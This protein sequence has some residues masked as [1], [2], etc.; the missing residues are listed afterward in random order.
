MRLCDIMSWH[1]ITHPRPV[2]DVNTTPFL[3]IQSMAIVT[4]I[5]PGKTCSK[6]MN[7]W[8]LFF[9]GSLWINHLITGHCCKESMRELI[10][11][12]KEYMSKFPTGNILFTWSD[13][14]RRLWWRPWCSRR[15]IRVHPWS[16]GPRDERTGRSRSR[17][18]RR[19][20]SW[21]SSRATPSNPCVLKPW[22]PT[23]TDLERR[24]IH[25]ETL[26]W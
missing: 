13:R 25:C 18:W 7:V 14:G 3:F 19:R 17:W 1:H 9:Q 16:T 6:N 26:E 4:I 5:L 10:L 12:A 15:R 23:V 2:C 20:L 22:R 21:W 24:Q 8:V 11:G